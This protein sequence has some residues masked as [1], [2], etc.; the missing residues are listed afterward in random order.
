[1]IVTT[2]EIAST[3]V[4]NPRLIIGEIKLK[5]SEQLIEAP[6]LTT[7][8]SDEIQ[9]DRPKCVDNMFDVGLITSDEGSS[10]VHM[11]RNHLSKSGRLSKLGAALQTYLWNLRTILI[12]SIRSYKAKILFDVGISF[13]FRFRRLGNRSD[14]EKAILTQGKAVELTS[15]GHPSKPERLSHLVHLQQTRFEC[16]GDLSDLHN[17]ISNQQK[18]VQLTDDGRPSKSAY[19]INLGYYQHTRFE[20]LGDLSDLENAISNQ[21]RAVQLTGDHPRPY[22]RNQLGRFLSRTERTK[23]VHLGRYL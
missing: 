5:L 23:L 3:E 20:Q 19:L 13:S 18:A 2:L 6:A 10:V 9:S 7:D 14:L 8:I 17:A 15:D 12:N 22:F 21:Q 11:S 4:G 1:L 16:L